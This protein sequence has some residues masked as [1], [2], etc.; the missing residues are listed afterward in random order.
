MPSSSSG[1]PSVSSSGPAGTASSQPP[2][3]KL[4]VA[5]IEAIL[6][7]IC[8]PSSAFNLP[9]YL[10]FISYHPLFPCILGD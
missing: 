6:V 2:R 7:R 9:I 5:E 8:C 10:A 3:T 1:P 4:T